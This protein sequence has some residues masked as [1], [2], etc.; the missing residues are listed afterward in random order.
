MKMRGMP[1]RKSAV[2][3]HTIPTKSGSKR[4]CGSLQS[5]GQFTVV[6]VWGSEV[7]VA[8]NKSGGRDTP[9]KF[10]LCNMKVYGSDALGNRESVK[11]LLFG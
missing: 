4:Q 8:E 7:E 2:S 10:L 6:G 5:F 11:D 3:K 1:S 9:L